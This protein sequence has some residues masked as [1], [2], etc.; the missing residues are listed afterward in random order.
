M[1]F[2]QTDRLR[3]E[4]SQKAGEPFDPE[5][6]RQTTRRLFATGRYRNI[7]VRVERT[8]M[9]VTLIFA[10]TPRYYVGRVQV[11]A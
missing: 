4:L 9:G 1:E 6:V 5:K 7:G 8:A 11:R 3:Q 2:D 10:G